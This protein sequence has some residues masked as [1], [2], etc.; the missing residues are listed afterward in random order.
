VSTD[1][2]PIP[3]LR[4]GRLVLRAIQ[5]EDIDAYYEVLFADPDVMRYLP[6]GEPLPRERLDGLV[7]R[8]HAH[9]EQHGYGVWVVCDVTSGEV[10]GQCGLRY[11]DE[12]DETE[13]LY[14]YARPTWGKGI[15][16]EGARAALDFGFEKAPL[17]R[18]VAYAV[19]ANSASTKVMEKLGMRYEAED[20]LFDLDLVRY[21]ISREEWEAAS[22]RSEAAPRR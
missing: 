3:E 12:V 16:T 13:I 14:A 4:T 7:E 20:H 11:L 22:G 17:Q 15:A 5:P 6:G 21:A 10:I 18:I 2:V 8:S 1:S 19:P 9:W